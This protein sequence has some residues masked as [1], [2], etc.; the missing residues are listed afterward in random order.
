[1]LVM[2]LTD[3]IDTKK[4]N[5]NRGYYVSYWETNVVP[6]YYVGCSVGYYIDFEKQPTLYP[7]L[8]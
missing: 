6:T 7:S 5:Y 8:W 1:M 3:V 4:L 2:T